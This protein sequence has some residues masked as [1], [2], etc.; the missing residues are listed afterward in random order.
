[1]SDVADGCAPLHPIQWEPNPNSAGLPPRPCMWAGVVNG[2]LVLVRR[3]HIPM[4]GIAGLVK[5][6]GEG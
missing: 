4:P 2:E 3:D 1:M 5:E 6:R